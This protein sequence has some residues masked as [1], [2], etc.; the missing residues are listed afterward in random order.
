[1]LTW[2]HS[3]DERI[4]GVNQSGSGGD[5]LLAGITTYVGVRPGMHV[6]LGTDWD[7][8][9]SAGTAFMPVRRHISFGITQQFRMHR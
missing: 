2:L 7:V 4:G 9:H 8:V 1:V 3:Q 6:W 5:V